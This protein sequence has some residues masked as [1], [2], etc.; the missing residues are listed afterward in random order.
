MRMDPS[1]M[2]PKQTMQAIRVHPPKSEPEPPYSA[3][4]PAPSTALVLDNIPIPALN[5]HGQ[6]LI[7]V[8]ATSVTRAELTWPETYETELPMMGYDLAGIVVAVHDDAQAGIE[9][10]GSVFKPG[11][12]VYGLLEMKKGST[13]AEFA[14]AQIDQVAAKPETLSWAESAAVPLSAL[15]AW[16]ALFV[17]A[18]IKPP[19]F[20]LIDETGLPSR[21]ETRSSKEIAITGATGAV[22]TWIVQLAALAGLHVVA[23]SR[24]YSS[25]VEFLISLG[26]NEVIEH[27]QFDELK[28]EFDIIIDSVGG[29]ILQKCWGSIKPDGTLISIASDSAD[30]VR[31]HRKEKFTEGKHNV[32][33]QFFIVEPS[34][35]QLEELR[36]A[37]DLGLLRVFVAEQMPLYRAREAYD[38]ANG[39]LPR[40]GKVILTI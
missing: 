22:G 25:E 33:A 10:P 26:A 13:W 5:K 31:R 37:L 16:Q 34:G 21:D 24:S 3:S 40:H 35:K 30:F 15:T 8:R 20:S 12:E 6:L 1:K 7:R 17:K 36:L 11:D 18:G 29:E 39:Q 32:K 2:D 19:D 23:V 14:I 28:D 4:N 27:R 9:G 38:L